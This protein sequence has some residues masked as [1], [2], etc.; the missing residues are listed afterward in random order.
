MAGGRQILW[1]LIPAVFLPVSHHNAVSAQ[2][3][4]DSALAPYPRLRE[5]PYGADAEELLQLL[6]LRASGSARFS[7][8]VVWRAEGT[9][10]LNPARDAYGPLSLKS[11]PDWG[12]EGR[13]SLPRRGKYRITVAGPNFL[14]ERQENESTVEWWRKEGE[15]IY[16]HKYT[17]QWPVVWRFHHD[18][19]E[20]DLLGYAEGLGFILWCFEPGEFL[21]RSENL[22]RGPDSPV[23]GKVYAT[24]I[25]TPDWIKEPP[26]LQ[27]RKHYPF[28]H[29]T[30]MSWAS[31]KPVVTYFVDTDKG[32]ITAAR[33]TYYDVGRSGPADWH[34][35]PKPSGTVI[36][37]VVSGFARGEGGS[38]YPRHITSQVFKKGRLLRSTDLTVEADSTPRPL[39]PLSL[40]GNKRKLDPWPLYRPQGFRYLIGIEGENHANRVGLARALC[41]EGDLAVGEKALLRAVEALEA[42]PN[43][44]AST[45]GGIDWE[46]GFALYELLWRFDESEIEGFWR[47]IPPTPTWKAILARALSL[48]KQYRPEEIRKIR[49]ILDEFEGTFDKRDRA[50]AERSS[51]ELY[52]EC[53]SEELE[54]AYKS[55]D[56][57]RIAEIQALIE[58]VQDLL[59]GR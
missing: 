24:L 58:E 30:M 2:E 40:P 21:R 7:A 29:S 47:R 4:Y 3:L 15:H 43:L 8:Q 39:P 14:I 53:L 5:K 48:Y 41:Y 51:W 31:L 49:I 25:A 52:L 59:D 19:L 10:K 27:N 46:L 22:E 17:K 42:D 57:K 54:A 44:T 34:A 23:N 13:S 37:S 16:S 28:N 38:Y 32:L 1:S 20:A 36:F 9:G 6:E 56:K 45:F 33:F 50:R 55:N 11:L 35:Q 26:F 12:N 18:A